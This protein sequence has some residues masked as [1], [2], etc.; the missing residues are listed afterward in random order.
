V[1]G[2]T[3]EDG[4][5]V[6]HL[7]PIQTSA[8]GAGFYSYAVIASNG[9]DEYTVENGSFDVELRADLNFDSDLRSHARKVLDAINAVIENRATVDQQSYS[10]AGRS[11]TRMS[12]DDLLK[13]KNVYQAQVAKEEG[14]TRWKIKT[15]L[16]SL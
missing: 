3:E 16:R 9:I 1:Y 7:T 15:V 14:K 13:F 4:M 5:F 6:L 12:L 2:T 8:F 11:L 10:I